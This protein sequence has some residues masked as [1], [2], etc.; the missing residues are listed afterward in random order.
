MTTIL[1]ALPQGPQLPW[2]QSGDSPELR[3]MQACAVASLADYDV[4]SLR[5]QYNRCSF[6]S[7]ALTYVGRDM[8]RVYRDAWLLA[9][10]HQARIVS[11]ART[12]ARTSPQQQQGG[13]GK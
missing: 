7:F 1:D 9:L 4:D 11:S 3:H 2:P 13:Q 5:D 8:R 12:H 6:G 10:E